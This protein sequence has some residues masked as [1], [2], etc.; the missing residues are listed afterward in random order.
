MYGTD[1]LCSYRQDILHKIYGSEKAL[2]ILIWMCHRLFRNKLDIG[3]K[4]QMTQAW[5]GRGG[6]EQGMNIE[7]RGNHA[8]KK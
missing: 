2:P 8:V 5:S 7:V 3:D 4:R 1:I 6:E